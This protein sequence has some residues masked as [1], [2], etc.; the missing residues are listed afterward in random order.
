MLAGLCTAAVVNAW[1]AVAQVGNQAIEI[2]VSG[3]LLRIPSEYF[4]G[5]LRSLAMKRLGG[6]WSLRFDNGVLKADEIAYRF[7]L[8]DGKPP[9]T[10]DSGPA[11]FWPPEPGRA[12]SSAEDF[13][14][15]AYSIRYLSAKEAARIRPFLP[16]PPLQSELEEKSVFEGIE[17]RTYRRTAHIRCQTPANADPSVKI[18]SLRPLNSF[19]PWISM[20]VFYRADDNLDFGVYFPAI[21]LRRWP[22]I[23]CITVAMLRSWRAVN[24]LAPP[25]CSKLPRVASREF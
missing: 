16:M 19:N 2:E 5:D 11:F 8:S 15:E 13:V 17:C 22:E 23:V 12:S 24:G 21:G 18:N 9:K 1:P 14:V 25:D 10:V 20:A 4:Q 6:A 7:W 3:V